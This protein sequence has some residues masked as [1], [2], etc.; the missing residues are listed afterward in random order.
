M[1]FENPG[2]YDEA[3]K[4]IREKSEKE[5]II[6]ENTIE[7][8]EKSKERITKKKSLDVFELKRRIETGKSLD[9]LKTEIEDALKEGNISFETYTKTLRD[10]RKKTSQSDED[11]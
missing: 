5:Q 2:A 8:F 9:S 11:M 1:P 3:R 7:N 10:L 6:V 4:R